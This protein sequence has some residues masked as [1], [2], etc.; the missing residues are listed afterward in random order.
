MKKYLIIYLAVFLIGFIVWS[1]LYYVYTASILGVAKFRI[2]YGIRAGL[3]LG[4]S[5]TGLIYWRDLE[6]KEKG[7]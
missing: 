1:G 6:D 7:D 4:I 3:V 5:I 2:D